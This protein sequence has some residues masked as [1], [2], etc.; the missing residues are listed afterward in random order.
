MVIYGIIYTYYHI[1]RCLSEDSHMKIKQ[2]DRKFR[3]PTRIVSKSD[4]IY[5][6]ETME[7]GYFVAIH[8]SRVKGRDCIG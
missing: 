3:L 5:L 7:Q 8:S 4:I 6:K 1:T 2:L